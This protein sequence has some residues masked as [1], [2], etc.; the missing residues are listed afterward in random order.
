[1]SFLIDFKTMLD[2]FKAI[3]NAKNVFKA[4]EAKI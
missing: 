2:D 1:M 3:F 4:E